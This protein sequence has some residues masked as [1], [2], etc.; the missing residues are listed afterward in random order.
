MRRIREVLRYH[1]DLELSNERISGALD[2][3][4]GSV[5]NILQRFKESSLSWPLPTDLTD[6]GLDAALFPSSGPSEPLST[7]PDIK[8][9]EKELARPHVT[10]QLLF[11][12]YR[13]N[14]PGGVSRA[15][16]YRYFNEHCTKPNTMK[17]AQKGGDL[18]YVDYSGDGPEYIDR[19]TGEVKPV[20]LFVS[21][22]GASSYSYA[23]STES[24]K[25]DDF[26]PSHVRAMDFFGV[27][28]AGIVPD[29]LK[30][31]VKKADRYEPEANPIY[32]AFARHYGTAILPAR[33]RKPQD[34]AVVESNVLHVQRYILARLRNRQFFSLGEINKAIRELLNDY[35]NR[36]MKDYGYA[37]RKERFGQLD[38]P[39]AK[40]L[41]AEPFKITRA[42]NDVK[43]A[44]NYHV[45]FNDHFYSVPHHLVGQRVDIY[46]AAN[47]IEIYHDHVHCCRHQVG[48]KR[49]GY[50]TK[51]EHMPPNHRFVKGW[52]AEWFLYQA[53]QIGDTCKEIVRQIMKSKD[54][55]QQGFNAAM[56]VLQLGRAYSPERLEAACQR[57]AY[58][59]CYNLQSLKAILKQNL[60]Q[61]QILFNPGGNQPPP[62]D[63]DNIRGSAYYGS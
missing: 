29:N 30:T 59:K 4:K 23:E 3:S 41:P 20:E 28:P 15:S 58:Y 26:V 36:P 12:E 32:A 54:H 21:S 6:S 39:Y 13:E 48:K 43:V 46:Q 38:K 53:G 35:N 33:V 37:S 50:T 10:L 44:P 19:K 45:R 61:Q 42:K 18:L 9:L 22:W 56:G 27:C 52:S 60:D 8:Y 49:F 17:M 24:Q 2:I 31:G 7:L 51:P 14:N 11:E 1:F 5:H 62:V 57:A 63:H 34:K 47:I 55:V 40:P 25:T 16:F